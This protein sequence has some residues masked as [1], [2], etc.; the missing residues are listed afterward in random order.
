MVMQVKK[1]LSNTV[2][3]HHEVPLEFQRCA[4]GPH[5]PRI[6]VNEEHTH[7]GPASRL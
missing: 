3:R 7:D 5:K 6:V 2:L 4:E 1:G